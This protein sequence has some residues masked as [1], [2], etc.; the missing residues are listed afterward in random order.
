VG[1]DFRARLCETRLRFGFSRVFRF[2]CRLT[3]AGS[4]FR[5]N[6]REHDAERQRDGVEHSCAV[7]FRGPTCDF[8]RDR[9]SRIE[10]TRGVRLGIARHRFADL[11]NA[12]TS[13]ATITE[14][15]RFVDGVC[16]L[17]EFPSNYLIEVHTSVS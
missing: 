9:S 7:D 2:V 14:S 3:D 5:L 6:Y 10:T 11:I 12:F 13:G 1:V 16:Y 17:V 8:F 4:G 15:M